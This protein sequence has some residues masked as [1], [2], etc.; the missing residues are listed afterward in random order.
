MRCDVRGVSALALG[1]G[2]M[3][4]AVTMGCRTQL[5]VR[6][7][8][9]FD[10]DCDVDEECDDGRCLRIVCDDGSAP[11][12]D[13]DA[14][15]QGDAGPNVDPNETPDAGPPS[16]LTDGTAYE[17]RRSDID[18]CVH[19]PSELLSAQT[20]G[21]ELD[22]V[23]KACNGTAAQRYWAR[24][25]GDGDFSLINASTGRCI[26]VENGSLEDL[27]NVLQLPCTRAGSQQWRD[28]SVGNGVFSLQNKNS[29]KV[30][31]VRGVQ[32][33]GDGST[34][35][36]GDI[37]QFAFDG[38]ADMKWRIT[39]NDTAAFVAL[40]PFATPDLVVRI[41]ADNVFTAVLASDTGPASTLRVLPGLADPAGVTFEPTA[42][43]GRV[44]RHKFSVVVADPNDQST[45]LRDDSTFFVRDDLRG[46]VGAEF[47][48]YES[49]NFPGSFLRVL[50]G[51][52]RID[53]NDNSQ[54]F[55]DSATWKLTPR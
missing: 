23:Q 53:A 5:P 9:A 33:G 46:E 31:E 41:E 2:F 21:A 40:V 38:S 50:D 42:F 37:D 44:L 17:L 39:P 11:P 3:V 1:F 54:A 19:A 55:K 43:P 20:V 48:S 10:R 15:V 13:V 26:A 29:G 36:D 35:Q 49:K 18:V 8:C 22:I 6:G 4:M 47:R 32:F 51:V 30:L 14:G 24:A 27:A 12:C 7:L 34:G 25:E 28:T 52:L 16:F 45:L